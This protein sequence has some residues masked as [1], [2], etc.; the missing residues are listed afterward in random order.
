[1]RVRRLKCVQCD[2]VVEG[3]FALS[4]FACLSPEQ[5]HF[6]EVF[7]VARGNI[8]EVERVLGIS[9]P[10]VRNRLDSVLETM[11]HSIPKEPIPDHRNRILEALNE[12][13][14]SVGEAIKQLRG[15]T[16]D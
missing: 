6:L 8:K 10:T 3:R 16:D 12:G 14:I 7:L 1:M 4:P 2:T 5:L 11:G 13:E 15:D 9:Y